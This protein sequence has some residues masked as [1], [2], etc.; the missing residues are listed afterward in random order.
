MPYA[1][2]KIMAEVSGHTSKHVNVNNIFHDINSILHTV[3]SMVGILLKVINVFIGENLASFT[4]TSI[5]SI[6]KSTKKKNSKTR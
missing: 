6:W 1:S 2:E 5:S 3:H 4:V